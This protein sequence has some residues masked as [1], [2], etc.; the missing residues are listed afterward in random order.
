MESKRTCFCTPIIHN[1]ARHNER[2]HTRN[3]DNMAVIFLDHRGQELPHHP[4][5]RDSV[6]LK[7]LLN[8]LFRTIQNR[9][10]CS[11]TSIVDQHGWIAVIFS[12]LC[13]CCCYFLDVRYV[14][15]VEEDTICFPSLAKVPHAETKSDR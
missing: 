5:M 15:L 7:R 14:A 4:E 13:C 10:S 6:H 1:I 3:R 9:Q 2:R 12:D 8:Y 11:N